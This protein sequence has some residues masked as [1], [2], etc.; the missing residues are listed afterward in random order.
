MICFY[1]DS[2]CRIYSPNIIYCVTFIVKITLLLLEKYN[3]NNHYI[4]CIEDHYYTVII[5]TKFRITIFYHL[6]SED[7]YS[8]FTTFYSLPCS[9]H[10]LLVVTVTREITTTQLWSPHQYEYKKGKIN[11]HYYVVVNITNIHF[12]YQ[13]VTILDSNVHFNSIDVHLSVFKAV[14]L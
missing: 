1:I 8:K 9:E 4:T 11:I 12:H 10:H 5:T 14:T 7:D 6:P 13:V 2:L 3:Y